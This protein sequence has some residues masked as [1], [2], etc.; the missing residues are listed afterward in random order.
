MC[1]C[2]EMKHLHIHNDDDDDGDA[3]KMYR[4]SCTSNIIISSIDD[5]YTSKTSSS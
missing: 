2:V 3:D 1:V 4:R 5:N